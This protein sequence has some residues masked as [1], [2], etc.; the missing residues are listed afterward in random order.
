MRFRPS[1]D[2]LEQ[3]RT[4][5][6]E[7]GNVLAA[8]AFWGCGAVEVTGIDYKR[9]G[10]V[11][12][13][14]DVFSGACN[15]NEIQTLL[16]CSNVKVRTLH[17]M[18]AKVWANGDHVIVASAN[19]SMNGLGFEAGD[20][21]VEAAVQLRNPT[22]AKQV[23][24]WFKKN[25]KVATKVDQQTLI[26]VKNIWDNRQKH[27][28]RR[29]MSYNIGAYNFKKLDGGVEEEWRARHPNAD[30]NKTSFY[31]Y[32]SNAAVPKPGTVI[33]DFTCEEQGGDFE[34]NGTWQIDGQPCPV[35]DGRQVVCLKRIDNPRFPN[36]IGR[37]GI[38]RMVSCS[39][40]DSGWDIDDDDWFLYKN[41]SDF[42]YA[43][44]ATCHNRVD[45]CEGC[46]VE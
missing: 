5:V 44:L 25:W 17:G 42:L 32:G 45:P 31:V 10:R 33:L 18:H 23:R 41:F 34:F 21:N 28:P 38:E 27:A 15:P 14:C 7:D 36:G 35:P 16:N 9:N 24:K 26:E 11:R 30:A 20:C 12:I 3:V 8:V 29:I 1:P 22:M 39:V 46:P 40:A 13:L 37:P 19:A 6:C 2:I 43:T 4:L